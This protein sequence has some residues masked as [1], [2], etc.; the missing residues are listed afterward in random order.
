MNDKQQ[1]SLNTCQELAAWLL[2]KGWE[3]NSRSVFTYQTGVPEYYALIKMNLITNEDI[4]VTMSKG[5]SENLEV[6]SYYCLPKYNTHLIVE[7]VV[8]RI[9]EYV[10]KVKKITPRQKLERFLKEHQALYDEQSEVYHFVLSNGLRFFISYLHG[11]KSFECTILQQGT[12]SLITNKHHFY[13]YF[14]DNDI[15]EFFSYVK[16]LKKRVPSKTG[17]VNPLDEKDSYFEESVASF[18]HEKSSFE[19]KAKRLRNILSDVLPEDW[20]FYLFIPQYIKETYMPKTFEIAF[21]GYNEW[22]E[23]V[24]DEIDVREIFERVYNVSHCDVM[25]SRYTVDIRK[26]DEEMFESQARE[27]YKQVYPVLKDFQDKK[28]RTHNNLQ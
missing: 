20:L 28:I 22:N 21:A 12:P 14:N 6:S 24:L 26:V 13:Q 25:G 2:E 23:E 1:C 4:E 11:G 17:W 15:K 10:E 8:N 3:Q 18:R 16:T 9:N 27:L 19:K 5:N 7:E